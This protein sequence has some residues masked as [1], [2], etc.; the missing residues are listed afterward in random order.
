M[1]DRR[2]KKYRGFARLALAVLLL[3]AL[4]PIGYMPASA[5]SGWLFQLCPDGLSPGTMA[6]LHAGHSDALVHAHHAVSQA[7]HEAG[8][9]AWS[10]DCPFAAFS[11]ATWVLPAE[12]AQRSEQAPSIHYVVDLTSAFISGTKYVAVQPRAPPATEIS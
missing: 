10:M 8:S 5:D 12:I 2:F 4:A 7:D 6:V 9:E 11:T 3:Q 1:S